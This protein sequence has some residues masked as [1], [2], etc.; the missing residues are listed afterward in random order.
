M[1]FRS[2][3]ALAV[4]MLLASAAPTFAQAAPTDKFRFDMAAPDLATANGYRYDLELDG[5]VLTTPLATTCVN[6]ASPFACSAPIPA[7]TPTTHVARVRAV[8]TSGP[9]P[10][11]GDWSDPLTFTMRATPA[12]PSGLT[13]TPGGSAGGANDNLVFDLGTVAPPIGQ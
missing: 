7:I 5:A 2:Y 3:L 10:I 1:R 12:K 9:T 11:L 8:D 6:A 4:L 13:I